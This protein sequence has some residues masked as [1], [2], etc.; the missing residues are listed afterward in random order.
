MAR[1]QSERGM[2]TNRIKRRKGNGE[3]SSLRRKVTHK[4][5]EICKRG[6]GREKDRKVEL[7]EKKDEKGNKKRKRTKGGMTRSWK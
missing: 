2:I 4:K 5:R 7:E 3:K 6:I 1:G